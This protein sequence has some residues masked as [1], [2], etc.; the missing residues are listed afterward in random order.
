MWLNMLAVKYYYIFSCLYGR[1]KCYGNFNLKTKLTL[2]LLE[3]NCTLNSLGSAK[4][5]YFVHKWHHGVLLYLENTFKLFL[6]LLT[7][8]GIT[9]IRKLCRPEC[10]CFFYTGLINP[11]NFS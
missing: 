6:C 2:F 11:T 1:W 5:P 9:G 4:T 10:Y 3:M 7:G 8:V